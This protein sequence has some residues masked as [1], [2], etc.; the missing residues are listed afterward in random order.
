MKYIK[1]MANLIQKLPDTLINQIAA[2]EVIERPA[3]IVKELIENSIDAAANSIS[4]ELEKGG[5]QRISIRDN[6]SGIEKTQ[7]EMAL[8]RHATSKITNLDELQIVATLGF[9]GEALPSIASVS[10]L[11]ITSNIEKS[12]Q[13]WRLRADGGMLEQ[14]LKPSA[15]T[16]GTTV[17]VNDLFYNTPARRKFMRTEKTEYSHCEQVVKRL[18]LANFHIK[19]ELRHNQKTIFSLPA[20]S[21]QDE[22]ENRLGKLLGAAFIEHA[23]FFERSVHEMRLSGWLAAPAFSRTQSDLQFQYVNNR[24]IRDKTLSH[25]V[26]LAYQDVL[27]HGRQPAYVIFLE[28]NPHSVD[29]NTHPAKHEVRFRDNRSMHDFVR[30]TLKQVISELRPAP[31]D[32]ENLSKLTP[33]VPTHTAPT[34]ARLMPGNASANE[35]FAQL[36]SSA[37]AEPR[38]QYSDIEPSILEQNHADAAPP[39]GYA[40][41]QLHGIYILAQNADGLILVDMHAAHERIV[42]EHLKNVESETTVIRQQL[43]VP[44]QIALTQ[45]EAQLAEQQ[46]DLFDSLGFEI[47]RSGEESIIIRAIPKILGH[48]DITVLIRDLLAD[49]QKN[50][51]STRIEQARD[52]ILSSIACHGSVRANRKMTIAEMNA[53]LRSMEITERSNQCNHGRPTWIQLSVKDLDKL[54][55][56]GR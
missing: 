7:L 6:G 30:Q 33:S 22:Q 48:S 11:N 44:I 5:I 15:H 45:S 55:L 23:I 50:K 13:G 47:N 31:I 19:F 4:I 37:V 25:A 53:L 1:Q 41:A 51:I 8:T 17:E 35:H 16:Q 12:N 43:L 9:R 10:R 42:Y 52:E 2:G 29:V 20:A 14:T 27:Y 39:L 49:W 28:L 54:F 32:S 21:T 38:M 26:K 3:S 56:R 18:A 46:Q 40:L 24:N 36:Y 34:Q